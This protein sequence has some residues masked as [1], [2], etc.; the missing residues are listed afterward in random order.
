MI[1]TSPLHNYH[2]YNSSPQGRVATIKPKDL[3][4]TN[5][6]YNSNTFSKFTRVLG[7]KQY[8]IQDHLG[9]VKLV[10]NDYKELTPISVGSEK[11][12]LNV[13]SLLNYYPFGMSMPGMGFEAGGSRYGFN[14]HEKDDEVSGVGNH[15]SFGNQG[16]SPRFGKR[17]NQDKVEHID[18]SP[19]VTF[20][21]DP[22]NNSDLDGNY[23]TRVGIML[24]QAEESYL[25]TGDKE[26]LMAHYKGNAVGTVIGIIVI[27]LPATV[28]LMVRNPVKTVNAVNAVGS[29]TVGLV[30]DGNQINTPGPIDDAGRATKGFVKATIGNLTKKVK[31]KIIKFD[32]LPSEGV[33]NP[34]SIRFSQESIRKTFKNGK[35]FSGMTSDLKSGKLN[36]KDVKP[37]RIV[38]KGGKI[39]TLDNRRL[40]AFQDANIDIPYQKVDYNKL[41]ERELQKF[42]T[43]NNGKTIRI[44][45]GKND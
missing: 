17:W 39:F 38:E 24:R 36:P 42:T 5:Y 43:E 37:I 14:G 30:D 23:E 16:Y 31:S 3:I 45:K 6:L 35:S 15:L 27:T 12:D 21:N 1:Q 19:Y 28:P 25:K 18:L 7:Q 33:V 11:Y 40:K 10:F 20:A 44:R 8:E 32:E 9:N 4:Y 22:I 2:I 29:F 13:L 34:K 41:P 26:A